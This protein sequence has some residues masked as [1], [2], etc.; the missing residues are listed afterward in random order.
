MCAVNNLT[1][2]ISSAC[3]LLRILCDKMSDCYNQP[4]TDTVPLRT[5]LSETL[6]VYLTPLS[7]M[8]APD[9]ISLLLVWQCGQLKDMTTT[10]RNIGILVKSSRVVP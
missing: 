8:G 3:S 4:L 10:S 5:V 6:M 7:C 2:W 1:N 9:W